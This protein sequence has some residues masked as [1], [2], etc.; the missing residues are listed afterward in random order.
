M[1]AATARLL[2]AHGARVAR[3]DRRTDRR[4]IIAKEIAFDGSQALAVTV[5]L[6]HEISVQSAAE[7]I[8]DAYGRVDLVVNTAGVMLPNP[9][10][11]APHTLTC[12]RQSSC[13]SGPG[14]PRWRR[15]AHPPCC[16]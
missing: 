16:G 10:D 7:R 1:G 8:R 12:G 3:L 15:G 11:A 14:T 6:T 2:A 5:D 9:V 13:R 4:G